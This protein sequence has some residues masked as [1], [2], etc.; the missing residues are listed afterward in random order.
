MV[1]KTEPFAVRA[2]NI[3]HLHSGAQIQNI[4]ITNNITHAL[5]AVSQK[6]VT[7]T[8][9]CYNLHESI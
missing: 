3:H 5:Y 9:S 7:K 6:N 1:P 8:L 4:Y 2:V